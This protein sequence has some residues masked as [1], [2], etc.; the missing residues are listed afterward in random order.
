LTIDPAGGLF[1]PP[2]LLAEAHLSQGIAVEADVAVDQIV[3]KP[4]APEQEA[5]L[6]ERDGMLVFEGGGPV[7]DDDVIRAIKA[8][9]EERT[10]LD[11]L[12]WQA[13]SASSGQAE[14]CSNGI[15]RECRRWRSVQTCFLFHL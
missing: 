15:G 6:V 3:V 12:C 8:D 13:R 10:D 14:R 9:R 1:L 5:R 2:E 7:T 4:A 11:C